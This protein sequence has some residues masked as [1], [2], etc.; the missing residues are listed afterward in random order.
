MDRVASAPISWGVC[1][2]PGWGIQLPPHRVLSE[3]RSLG[4]RATELGSIGFLPTD[5]GLLRAVLDEHDMRLTGGFVPLPLHD[6]GAAAQ[7][8]EAATEAA[9][10]LAAAGADYFVTCAVSDPHNWKRPELDASQWQ[11]LI[12]MLDVVEAVAS[13]QG[14]VQAV[15]PHVDS[16][17]ETGDEIQRVCD[18]SPA[19]WVLETGHMAIGGCDPLRF[20]REFAS[21][22]AVVHLKDV[23]LPI[24]HQL[25]IGELSL[26][27]AV[28]AGLFP[29][30]GQ[31]DVAIAEVIRM[32]EGSGYDGW[33]VIEQDVAISGTEP[34][35]GCGP[36]RDVE[37]SVAYIRSIDFD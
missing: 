29:P 30:L 8:V 9:A 13:E 2:V 14:L 11:H 28:Q 12:E 3:M 4:I 5:P 15:H 20:A 35:S 18:S 7:T 21:K 16:L 10:L 26:M 6:R 34:V 25:N 33:Y 22:V 23:R 24:V 19:R 37:T 27:A 36:I 1:E 32:L 31:G 17:I